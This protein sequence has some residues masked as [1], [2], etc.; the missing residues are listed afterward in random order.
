[1]QKKLSKC[2]GYH[3]QDHHHDHASAHAYV[4]TDAA[5]DPV[6]STVLPLYSFRKRGSG[7][8]PND[9]SRLLEK[10]AD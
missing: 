7:Y 4:Q 8:C 6:G 2:G 3:I 1:V 9:I 5:P 10:A